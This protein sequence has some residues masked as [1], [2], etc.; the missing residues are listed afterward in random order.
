MSAPW[1]SKSWAVSVALFLAARCSG[2]SPSWSFSLMLAPCVSKTLVVS[3]ALFHTAQCSGVRPNVSLA[4]IS[5][6]CVINSWAVSVAFFA[7]A[8]CSGVASSLFLVLTSWILANTTKPMTKST[9]AP[10]ILANRRT[11]V[12]FGGSLLISVLAIGWQCLVVLAAALGF[13]YCSLEPTFALRDGSLMSKT[14]V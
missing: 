10:K 3:A 11:L 7:A 9:T 5:A 1:V 6:P 8:Q 14:I 13:C 12:F 4:Q 2:V